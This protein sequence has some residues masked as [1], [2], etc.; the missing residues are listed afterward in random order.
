MTKKEQLDQLIKRNEELS[1]I[2]FVGFKTSKELEEYTNT[3]KA[4]REEYYGN[5]PKIKKLTWELMTPEEQAKRI[6]T[7]RKILTKKGSNSQAEILEI[8]R[9]KIEKEGGL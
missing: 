3:I 9:D 7:V 2:I 5:L 4:E 1:P 6:E 8:I